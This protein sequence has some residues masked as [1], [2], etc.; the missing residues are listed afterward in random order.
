[1]IGEAWGV[2]LGTIMGEMLSS[3]DG[4][5]FERSN[6]GV[7]IDLSGVSNL[8]LLELIAVPSTSSRLS[9]ESDISGVPNMPP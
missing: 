3:E 8:M 5:L 9:L 2:S 6:T 1:M 7:F 4:G